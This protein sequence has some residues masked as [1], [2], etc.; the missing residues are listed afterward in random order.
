MDYHSGFYCC[1]TYYNIYN[2]NLK[3]GEFLRYD[4]WSHPNTE[5]DCCVKYYLESMLHNPKGY[6]YLYYHYESLKN[7]CVA[8]RYIKGVQIGVIEY[9]YI[10]KHN[11]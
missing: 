11:R 2:K 7:P 6:A 3:C 1:Q 9:P 8:I 10:L 5:S 4:K